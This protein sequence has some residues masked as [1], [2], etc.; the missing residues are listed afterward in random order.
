[1]LKPNGTSEVTAT[2]AGSTSFRYIV[3]MGQ[4]AWRNEVAL[5]FERCAASLRANRDRQAGADFG[6]A[7][8]YLQR[9]EEDGER[10]AISL[11]VQARSVRGDDRTER[12]SFVPGE[13]ENLS[14]RGNSKE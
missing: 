3:S 5:L 13:L 12:F 14:G 10:G 8:A 11:L 1:L 2:R 9:A 4:D 6:T 7:I